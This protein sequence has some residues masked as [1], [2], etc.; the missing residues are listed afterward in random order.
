MRP[1]RGR[2]PRPSGTNRC[3]GGSS[4]RWE[5][6]WPSPRFA[7]RRTTRRVL[8]ARSSGSARARTPS[9]ALVSS[10]SARP[11]TASSRR[12]DAD[13]EGGR[14][15]RNGQS[16]RRMPLHPTRSR[17][18][19][20]RAAARPIG[21]P[22]TKSEEAPRCGSGADVDRQS[23]RTNHARFPGG[24]R[25][26]AAMRQRPRPTAGGNTDTRVGQK[27]SHGA[28]RRSRRGGRPTPCRGLPGRQSRGPGALLA[29]LTD[30]HGGFDHSPLPS[31]S[32]TQRAAGARHGGRI[33]KAVKND[34]L[35][36]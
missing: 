1:C 3:V 26:D 17:G 4:S 36:R 18:D 2:G 16:C 14:P 9:T 31:P 7:P 13:P 23:P 21:P 11:S 12:H 5:R 24:R 10:T 35:F 33:Q 28:D 19:R 20:I 25:V 32:A 30:R 6:S 29:L 15:T 8:A 27:R 22:S 34:C